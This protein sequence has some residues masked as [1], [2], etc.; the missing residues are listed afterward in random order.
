MIYSVPPTRSVSH[1]HPL[2]SLLHSHIHRSE[3]LSSM[4]LC[5]AP[6]TYATSGKP[7][8]HRQTRADN[9]IWR[10]TWEHGRSLLFAVEQAPGQKLDSW[11]LYL[12]GNRPLGVK[13]RTE[14]I[15][16]YIHKN[17]PP[18]L[19]Q[20]MN[21]LLHRPGQA[22]WTVLAAV[23]Y[24]CPPAE[25]PES[26]KINCTDKR[27]ENI[28]KYLLH[29]IYKQTLWPLVRKWTIPTERPSLVEEI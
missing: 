19:Q 23:T 7:P 22:F 26:L 14:I 29:Y 28:I 11:A 15:S 3:C 10:R 24:I 13:R 16:V 2:L 27:K 8:S 21:M 6:P 1:Y 5:F 20:N 12:R 25:R 4:K 18:P 17:S 9:F